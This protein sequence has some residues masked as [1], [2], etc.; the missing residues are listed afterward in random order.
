MRAEV[1]N[2]DGAFDGYVEEDGTFTCE[3]VDESEEDIC[4]REECCLPTDHVAQRG[5]WWERSVSWSVDWA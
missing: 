1:L 5:Y 4:S 2:Q 3:S